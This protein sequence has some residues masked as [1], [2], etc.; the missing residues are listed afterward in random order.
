MHYGKRSP[1]GRIIDQVIRALAIALLIVVV[2]FL[3]AVAFHPDEGS[4][5]RSEALWRIFG[6]GAYVGFAALFVIPVVALAHLVF[7]LAARRS[8]PGRGRSQA[9]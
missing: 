9:E 2:G 5:L 7:R 4:V 6:I 1:D 3:G 8:T